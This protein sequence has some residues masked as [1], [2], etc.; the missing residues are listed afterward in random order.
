MMKMPPSQ[1][2][3]HLGA[4]LFGLA[5]AGCA[6]GP[7]YRRPDVAAP[8]A[9]KEAA[10]W[11]LATPRDET[12]RGAWWEIYRDPVLNSLEQRATKG[13][14]SILAADAAY[15]AAAAI[16]RQAEASLWPTLG[17]SAGI[18]RSQQ[19][20]GT[21]RANSIQSAPTSGLNNLR[22]AE[23]TASWEVDLWGG[24]RRSAES[25]RASAAATLGDYEAAKLS[26]AAEL[27]VDYFDLRVADATQ[28]FL[29]ETVAGYERSLK[30]S[31]NQYAAGIVGRV[32]VAEAETQLAST[33]AQAIDVGIQRAQLEHAIAVLIGVPPAEFSV[34][35]DPA[36]TAPSPDVPLGVAGDLLERRPDI[37]AAER[38]VVAANAQVGVASAAWFP[39]LTLNATGG[40]QSVAASQWFSLPNRFWSVGPELAETL[41]DAGRRRAVSAQARA[42][43]DQAVANYR[44]TT[45]QAFQDVEDSL[46]SLRVLKDEIATQDMAVKSARE[47]ARLTLNQYKAG[48]VSYLSVVTV[49]ETALQNERAAISLIGRQ[50]AGSVGLV[51]G[52][53]GGWRAEDLNAAK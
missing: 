30:I 12:V 35:V 31:Q 27:A 46:V 25:S 10:S 16:A 26:L 13:N 41:F 3:L 15:R 32:D 11:Q 40:Y 28:G 21:A 43:Y 51:R 5:A 49:Q 53:G 6:V 47:A 52:L 42:A 29:N 39:T 22:T 38:R 9:F 14:Q 44:Q 17:A 19:A 33:R 37:A 1:S 36:W 34:A 4:A 48:T 50:L 45:L 7:D 8:A 2:R 24:L 23:L 20:V 18:T